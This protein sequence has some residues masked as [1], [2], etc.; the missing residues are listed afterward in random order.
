V[1]HEAP[2]AE[3]DSLQQLVEA[4]QLALVQAALLAVDLEHRAVFI[5][6]ELDEI[7]MPETAQALGIPLNTGYSRL[8]AARRKFESALQRL[9]RGGGK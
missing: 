2:T 9:Q 5:L 6:H 8:R 4:Q 3:R 7:P 1:G